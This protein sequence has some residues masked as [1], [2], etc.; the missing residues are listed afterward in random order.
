MR[1]LFK[2]SNL[3]MHPAMHQIFLDMGSQ[4]QI[5]PCARQAYISLLMFLPINR[6]TSPLFQRAK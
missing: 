2:V 3:I 6:A 4:N 1:S 5:V